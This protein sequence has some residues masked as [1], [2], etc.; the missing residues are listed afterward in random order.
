MILGVGRG[1][2]GRQKA[3]ICLGSKGEFGNCVGSP[4]D[5]SE[6]EFQVCRKPQFTYGVEK[7]IFETGRMILG[8]S[9]SS[10][11]TANNQAGDPESSVYCTTSQSSL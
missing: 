5:H 2:L 10:V 11:I 3:E 7:V 1:L 9:T 4:G 6:G 8:H